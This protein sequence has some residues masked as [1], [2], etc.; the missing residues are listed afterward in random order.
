[1]RL[2]LV[3]VATGRRLTKRVHRVGRRDVEHDL[4]VVVGAARKSRS[5][6]T[7]RTHGR[8]RL[9]PCKRPPARPLCHS[10]LV[11]SRRSRR[12]SAWPLCRA[13]SAMIFRR[14]HRKVRPCPAGSVQGC[15]RRDD[16]V[17]AVALTS[18]YRERLPRVGRR[19]ALKV[20]LRVCVRAVDRRQ[21]F[22][23]DTSAEVRAFHLAQVAREPEE[24]QSRRRDAHLDE[25]FARESDALA[26]EGCALVPKPA[27][28]GLALAPHSRVRTRR[29]RRNLDDPSHGRARYHRTRPC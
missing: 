9:F 7:H 19:G 10:L 5:S 24:G 25:L 3:R 15:D 12:R 16:R 1:M 29:L 14:L 13:Y 22:P 17:R 18:P 11:P 8:T 23:A 26:S 28:K 27:E 4:A 6:H 2:E 21:W 20:S